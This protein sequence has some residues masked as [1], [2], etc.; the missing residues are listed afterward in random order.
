M[1]SSQYS[2]NMDS[3]CPFKVVTEK[4]TLIKALD[5]E[6]LIPAVEKGLA[7]FS[8]RTQG[9]VIQPVRTVINI[10]GNNGFFGS[11]PVYSKVDDIIATKLVSFFPQ[12]TSVATHNAVVLVFSTETGVMRAILDGD[13][14][15]IRRTAAASAVAT[16]YLADC[17]SANILAILGSGAQARSHYEAI[18]QLCKFS[19]IRIWNH[20]FE[21]AEKLAK[22]LGPAAAA[23]ASAEEAVRDADVIVTVT[24]SSVP[25]LRAEW[26]KPGAH[27]NAVGACRPDW[28]E[29][30]PKLMRDCVLY[31]DSRE[32]AEK[33]SGDVIMSGASVHAEIGEVVTDPSLARPRQTTVFKSLGVAI[34]DAVAAKLVVDKLSIP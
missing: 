4:Q 3:G 25:I 24:S 33:E 13:V 18:S 1:H 12:N 29:L 26:V 20:R 5:Y 27:V 34:E 19:E 32:G 7:T 15:T 10:P 8:R 31:V 28:A 14:I 11:M 16:K 2:F 22:E 9:E 21:G 6:D 17:S 23:C 30:D